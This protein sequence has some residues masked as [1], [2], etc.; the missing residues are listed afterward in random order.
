MNTYHAFTSRSYQTSLVLVTT[1][2]NMT[3]SLGVSF[4]Q[5]FCKAYWAWHTAVI[6]WADCTIITLL[7]KLLDTKML[8]PLML[9]RVQDNNMCWTVQQSTV[10]TSRETTT[11]ETKIPKGLD[12]F[13][14][15]FWSRSSSKQYLTF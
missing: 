6:C 2:R 1:G 5:A 9:S 8:S 4:G 7:T 15:T 11:L 3:C 12:K 14:V 13:C 10:R